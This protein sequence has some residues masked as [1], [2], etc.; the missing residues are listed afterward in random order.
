MYGFAL[1]PMKRTRKN[2]CLKCTA[3]SRGADAEFIHEVL[4]VPMCGYCNKAF[5]DR[6]LF[7]NEKPSEDENK[8]G[9]KNENV[10]LWCGCDN[11]VALMMCDTCTSSFCQLCV[12]R[13]FGHR[14]MCRIKELKRWSCFVCTPTPN[15]LKLQISSETNLFSVEKAYRSVKLPTNNHNNMAPGMM[16]SLSGCE[17]LFLSLVIDS[18][19]K[20]LFCDVRIIDFLHAADFCTMPRLSRNLRFCFKNII[21]T[22]GLFK[23]H[24]GEQYNCRLHPHQWAS[25]SQMVGV[26]N[27]QTHFGA[28]R[29]GILADAPGLGKTVTALALIAS[30]I[31]ALPKVPEGTCMLAPSEEELAELWRGTIG[32]PVQGRAIWAVLCDVRKTAPSSVD[33]MLEFEDV[34]K[35]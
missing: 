27:R 15:L 3:C 17:Q 6:V 4:Q 16:E 30:S 13:N 10:C 12:A 31:G 24:F 7:F 18:V 11:D 26:E 19:G 22:P 20:A 8:E 9:F 33:G 34:R 32:N 1:R 29:G 35:R 25:L 23:T 2:E 28:V 14:E 21:S 5:R